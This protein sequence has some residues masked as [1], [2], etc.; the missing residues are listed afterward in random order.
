MD[1][2]AASEVAD[3]LEGVTDLESRFPRSGA[4]CE[5]LDDETDSVQDRHAAQHSQVHTLSW[6][7]DTRAESFSG[8]QLGG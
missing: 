4:L 8:P 7:N 1:K 2:Q 6:A 3:E 5:D